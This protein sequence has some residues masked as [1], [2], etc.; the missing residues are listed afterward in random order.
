MSQKTK[1]RRGF[2]KEAEALSVSHREALG[3]TVKQA[4]P[5]RRLARRL[6][7]RVVSTAAVA[8]AL[9][10]DLYAAFAEYLGRPAGEAV[11]SLQRD[12]EGFFAFFAEVGGHRMVFYNPSCEPAR[13][14][15]DLMHEMAHV[16]CGH[17]GQAIP[18]GTDF[19]LRA[20]DPVHEEEAHRMGSILQIPEDGLFWHLVDG[21]TDEEIAKIYGA[22][23]QM[24]RWRKSKSGATRRAAACG[25]GEACRGGVP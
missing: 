23:L 4:C 11:A 6:G 14:E 12:G 25:S 22:S 21:R 19:A 17:E 24:V 2:V 8:P 13:Q 9:S 18:F 1:L 10:A 15:S 16:I 3:L 20:H 5:A 7:L